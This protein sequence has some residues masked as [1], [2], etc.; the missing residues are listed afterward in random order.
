MQTPSDVEIVRLSLVDS[1]N[2]V[3]I[4]ERYQAKLLRYI[5]RF[6]ALSLESA[7]DVLQET[8]IKAYRYLNDFDQEL[9]F[10]SWIYRIAHNET[11]NYL[12][13]NKQQNVSLDM[14]DE[15]GK[16]LA[17]VLADDFDLAEEIE[18]QDLGAEVRHIL[19]NLSTDFREVLILRYLEQKSYQ[20]ISQIL[21]KPEGTV[22]TLLNRAK[23][24][25]KMLVEKNNLN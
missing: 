15:E 14:P 19:Q 5:Q 11:V 8:F 1:E 6:S 3:L 25:F 16:I 17:D 23:V 24:Q 9:S 21:K 22:S 12:R 4:V 13:R 7:E 20:E 10:G 2:F 18:K